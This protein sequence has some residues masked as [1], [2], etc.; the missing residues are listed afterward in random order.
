MVVTHRAVSL[1]EIG[2]TAQNRLDSRYYILREKTVP[3][4]GAL[5]RP[6]PLSEI[7]CGVA[8]GKNLP[9]SIYADDPEEAGALYASVAA[10]SQFAF[11]PGA[12]TPLLVDERGRVTGKWKASDIAVGFDELLVTRSGTPGIAVTGRDMAAAD[13]PVIPSGFLI[14]LSLKRFEATYVAAILNHPIWRLNTFAISAGKRQDNISQG[15]LRYISVPDVPGSVRESVSSTYGDCLQSISSVLEDNSR[16]E[17]TCDD[18]LHASTSLPLLQISYRSIA[19]RT[20]LLHEVSEIPGQ[21]FDNRW[22]GL[23]NKEARRA[24]V[25]IGCQP[26]G[27]LL[28][29]APRRGRQPVKVD[30]EEA[31]EDSP[32]A[33]TT[34]SIQNG[35]IVEALA[36]PTADSAVE[37]FE[38]RAGDVLVAMDGDGSLGKAAL[39]PSLDRRL[40]ADSHVGRLR[41]RDPG[42]AMAVCCFINST[43]GKVQTAGVMTGSTGQ[44]QLSANDLER[45]LVS[46]EAFEKA[47]AVGM[48]YAAAM[49]RFEFPAQQARR[50]LSEGAAQ[51]GELLLEAAAFGSVDPTPIADVDK[52]RANLELIHAMQR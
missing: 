34:A 24:L 27:N 44:T 9:A 47:E 2:R 14:R 39:V 15:S 12:C 40:T 51:I 52:I 49:E 20:I 26:L 16:F 1:D 28:L 29:E 50:L 23:A 38:V 19:H 35:Q 5:R 13:V 48:S 32:L 36:R 22:H 4:L 3:A 18:V 43:W 7:A 41:F 42:H 33:V 6:L 30:P 46:S 11:R 45:V 25:E 37:K 17:S 31:A 21:R 10:L 8:N